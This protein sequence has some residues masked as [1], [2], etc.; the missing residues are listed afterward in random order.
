MVYSIFT[1]LTVQQSVIIMQAISCLRENA[2]FE[3]FLRNTN[4]RKMTFKKGIF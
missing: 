2:L 4:H 1:S 3:L